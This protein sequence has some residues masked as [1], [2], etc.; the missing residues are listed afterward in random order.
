MH[1]WEY[2]R[3]SAYTQDLGIHTYSA[4]YWKYIYWNWSCF[5]Q[6]TARMMIHLVKPLPILLPMS[7]LDDFTCGRIACSNSNLS[8]N[9]STK[10]RWLFWTLSVVTSH[11]YNLA[12]YIYHCQNQGH[13]NFL[14]Y[15]YKRYNLNYFFFEREI[16][17]RMCLTQQATEVK[18]S[19]HAHYSHDVVLWKIVGHELCF[20]FC[21]HEHDNDMNSWHRG[22]CTLVQAFC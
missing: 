10:N 19:V 1:A 16:L 20:M 15:L 9:I 2:N 22:F 3:F 13:Y 14:W 11:G 6:Q 21:R 5:M 12:L 7:G 17:S 8:S 4:L 18:K